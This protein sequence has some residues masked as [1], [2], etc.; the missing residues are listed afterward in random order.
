MFYGQEYC[1]KHIASVNILHKESPQRGNSHESK[2]SLALIA[3]QQW[4]WLIDALSSPDVPCELL[5]GSGDCLTG[6][7]VK[8]SYE[9][10]YEDTI[11]SDRTLGLFLNKEQAGKR[12]RANYRWI[13]QS[14]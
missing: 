2:P 3:G 11:A 14:C 10:G 13:I 12:Q 9:G 1:M 6:Q 7:E 8:R 4:P 5:G